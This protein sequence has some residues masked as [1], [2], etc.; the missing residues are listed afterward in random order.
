MAEG[1]PKTKLSG[2]IERIGPDGTVH[3]FPRDLGWDE[4]K[5]DKRMLREVGVSGTPNAPFSIPLPQGYDIDEAQFP[6]GWQEYQARNKVFEDY[7]VGRKFRSQ[8]ELEELRRVSPIIERYERSWGLDEQADLLGADPEARRLRSL[9]QRDRDESFGELSALAMFY[10]DRFRSMMGGLTGEDY[11]P[12]EGP[13]M[14]GMEVSAEQGMEYL[15]KN[16]SLPYYQRLREI[17]G[18]LIPEPGESPD[19][20]KVRKKTSPPKGIRGFGLKP[21]F[22][23]PK[24]DSALRSRSILPLNEENISLPMTLSGYSTDNPDDTMIKPAPPDLVKQA[25]DNPQ[26]GT[27]SLQQW[28]INQVPRS[29][30]EQQRNRYFNRAVPLLVQY[31]LTQERLESTGFRGHMYRPEDAYE[32]LR[33]SYAADLTNYGNEKAYIDALDAARPYIEQTH[34]KLIQEFGEPGRDETWIRARDAYRKMLVGYV[35]SGR[36]NPRAIKYPVTLFSQLGDDFA[37]DVDM[38][39]SGV[40][41]LEMNQTRNFFKAVAEGQA[42][43]QK[44][45]VSELL[46]AESLRRA[47]RQK[48]LTGKGYVWVH[49]ETGEPAPDEYLDFYFKR[50][51]IPMGQRSYL[52]P[53]DPLLTK[54]HRYTMQDGTSFFGFVPVKQSI[55][56]VGVEFM[57]KS[58]QSLG[59]SNIDPSSKADNYT[60]WM[61]TMS[62]GL[63]LDKLVKL[64]EEKYWTDIQSP[65]NYLLAEPWGLSRGVVRSVAPLTEMAA[66]LGFIEG[67]AVEEGKERYASLYGQNVADIESRWGKL[68][69]DTPGVAAYSFGGQLIENIATDTWDVFSGLVHILG[70]VTQMSPSERIQIQEAV[71][72]QALREMNVAPR[73]LT[74]DEQFVSHVKARGEDWAEIVDGMGAFIAYA[75]SDILGLEGKGSTLGKTFGARPLS[76]LLT[77]LDGARIIAKSPAGAAL[78]PAKRKALNAAI[79]QGDIY[80]RR[81]MFAPLVLMSAITRKAQRFFDQKAKIGPE[82]KIN[83]L[84]DETING[85]RSVDRLFDQDVER[86]QTALDEYGV[87]GDL[88]LVNDA[89]SLVSDA[90]KLAVL[91]GVDVAFSKALG[92]KIQSPMEIAAAV[93]A[94]APDNPA[95]R[96]FADVIADAVVE[97]GMARDATLS[98]QGLPGLQQTLMGVMLPYTDRG[99]RN[100]GSY[101][102]GSPDLWMDKDGATSN[103]PVHVATRVLDEY[104]QGIENANPAFLHVDPALYARALMDAAQTLHRRSD[105]PAHLAFMEGVAKMVQEAAPRKGQ[106]VGYHEWS[107][108]TP[109]VLKAKE[110]L[111]LYENRNY[112]LGNPAIEN[113]TA[114]SGGAPT[115]VHPEV[116]QALHQFHDIHTALVDQ[117]KKDGFIKGTTPEQIA[118]ELTNNVVRL[119]LGGRLDSWHRKQLVD[120]DPGRSAQVQKLIQ[121]MYTVARP[122][123]NPKGALRERGFIDGSLA[124]YI[125]N[126][127]QIDPHVIVKI[128]RRNP[129]LVEKSVP[130]FMAD[131]LAVPATPEAYIGPAGI[132][133]VK[134]K[135]T[136]VLDEWWFDPDAPTVTP[137]AIV[138]RKR[139]RFIP[140]EDIGSLQE[141]FSE[142]RGY[143][144]V[145]TEYFTKPTVEGMNVAGL[146][147]YIMGRRAA[148]AE[149]IAKRKKGQSL[150]PEEA[151]QLEVRD[152]YSGHNKVVKSLFL[153]KE[154]R[155]KPMTQKRYDA[156]T[157]RERFQLQSE[158]AQLHADALRSYIE[159]AEQGKAA[160]WKPPKN[161]TMVK[162]K[163]QPGK[164]PK[165]PK[166]LDELAGKRS[167]RV[168]MEG[169]GQLS[170]EQALPVDV[171]GDALS[172]RG[173]YDY[174]TI[175][176]GDEG[177]QAFTPKE[178]PSR[179][180]HVVKPGYEMTR[181]IPEEPTVLQQTLDANAAALSERV[182]RIWNAHKD[183]DLVQAAKV[184]AEFT[185]ALGA[186]TKIQAQRAHG[187][188]MLIKHSD[189]WNAERNMTVAEAQFLDTLDRIVSPSDTVSTLPAWLSMAPEQFRALVME[190]SAPDLV[191]QNVLSRL[192]DMGT[193][194]GETGMGVRRWFGLGDDGTITGSADLLGPG[195]PEIKVQGFS[196]AAARVYQQELTFLDTIANQKSFVW[197]LATSLKSSRSARQ[198]STFIN[199]ALNNLTLKMIVDGDFMAPIT[200]WKNNAIYNSYL[201]NPNSV[202]S[203]NR[204]AMRAVYDTG[205]VKTDFNTAELGLWDKALAETMTE[206][207]YKKVAERQLV[208]EM[209]AGIVKRIVNKGLEGLW[210]ITRNLLSRPGNV[211]KK[212]Y[213]ASDNIMKVSDIADA[214]RQMQPLWEKISPGDSVAFRVSE[215][216]WATVERLPV[217]QSNLSGTKWRIDGV[218]KTIEPGKLRSNADLNL[219]AAK[220]GALR[221]NRKYFDYSDLSP[222]Q[223]T[224]RKNGFDQFFSPYYTWTYK[225]MW[226]P[227]IKRGWM[228]EFLTGQKEI[229]TNSK[230]LQRELDVVDTS[231]IMRRQIAWHTLRSAGQDKDRESMLNRMLSY[232]IDKGM[233]MVI[234]WM[235]PGL[236]SVDSLAGLDPSGPQRSAFRLALETARGAWNLGAKMGAVPALEPDKNHWMIV[237]RDDENIPDIR[238]RLGEIRISLTKYSPK[239]RMKL[240]NTKQQ[241]ITLKSLGVVE[242]MTDE[243]IVAL[244]KSAR[245]AFPANPS[246]WT[247]A[248]IAF[249]MEKGMLQDILNTYYQFSESGKWKQMRAP[250]DWQGAVRRFIPYIVG[251]GTIGGAADVLIGGIDEESLFSSR[252][253]SIPEEGMPQE[254]MGAYATRVM[255]GL[256]G[257]YK[258]LGLT[259][260]GSFIMDANGKRWRGGW[261]LKRMMSLRDEWVQASKGASRA[262]REM[263]R[264]KRL[265][266]LREQLIRDAVQ[267]GAVHVETDLMLEVLEGETRDLVS[268]LRERAKTLGFIPTGKQEQVEPPMDQDSGGGLPQIKIGPEVNQ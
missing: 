61:S 141:I 40:S 45:P 72:A 71:K 58:K 245:D 139:G 126:G 225:S 193:V 28:Y 19:A 54:K 34:P 65:L 255:T 31:D 260:D 149:A 123:Q 243:E 70:Q 50:K 46:D 14:S 33:P 134:M 268:G 111:L 22:T 62:E 116:V 208:D 142:E 98:S 37:L 239:E 232:R 258:S 60:E 207:L 8:S 57:E 215:M 169:V 177:L 74:T 41:P 77:V 127:L 237:G 159:L 20:F 203:S 155:G 56:A 95:G 84:A 164:T 109:A 9:A 199:N 66:G 10:P 180:S 59:W 209:P 236:V 210:G 150:T 107:S 201:D 162:R 143:P 223:Q 106:G 36:L 157:N 144:R 112:K 121:E 68:V 82:V 161:S 47:E 91:D 172:P 137:E 32:T 110:A 248:M 182:E 48:N 90:N 200:V 165:I 242:G 25:I 4:G 249:G 189:G 138:E 192:D 176:V 228:S 152:R 3:E 85:R 79:R 224:L 97:N 148:S 87:T 185:D 131:Q 130:T 133:Q 184:A 92:E 78:N 253:Y 166:A 120:I 234:R 15:T 52:G 124:D 212:A 267:R 205:A 235:A 198:I 181:F 202:S 99:R 63:P 206:S 222:W 11:S 114:E 43:S 129:A 27:T 16:M 6:A 227:G 93:D 2:N 250:G 29:Y 230:A 64:R 103:N 214:A 170:P 211:I 89:M 24:I 265:P 226:M 151:A 146:V 88:A 173:L 247:D 80:A 167:L 156:M 191:K 259:A 179:A 105:S 147:E 102:E 168:D 220:E 256:G 136:A 1:D 94:L 204:A 122:R 190:T 216:R 101:V 115:W 262:E 187:Q 197:K 266:S 81:M 186:T 263:D 119:E 183:M 195:S 42:A 12:Q 55:D 67:R 171:V 254:P 261:M 73:P 69:E 194:T 158:T 135:P 221:A 96:P 251:G 18:K 240:F 117:L 44:I 145:P 175:M 75:G 100:R 39:A 153:P 246:P 217:S 229:R 257:Y 163:A 113:L 132:R 86:V 231:R 21:Y 76:T 218:E 160:E 174:N 233:P 38:L 51:S 53:T 49:P 7:G 35:Y 23:N 264:K 108:N 17:E 196:K 83:I 104:G 219:I 213:G 241:T 244:R 178:F 30:D 26:A 188:K 118:S 125:A 238:R 154:Y 5:V 252:H 13:T 140:E 128:L